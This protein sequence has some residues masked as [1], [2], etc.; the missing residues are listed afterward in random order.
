MRSDERDGISLC[1]DHTQMMFYDLD[2]FLRLWPVQHR[3][4]RPDRPTSE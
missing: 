3:D 2:E 1:Y 4:I